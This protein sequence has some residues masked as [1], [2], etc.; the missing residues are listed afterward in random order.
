MRERDFV[1]F[2]TVSFFRDRN[3][4]AADLAARYGG[5]PDVMC[6]S[7]DGEP[8]CIGGTLEVRPGVVTLLFFA[9]DAFPRIGLGITRF[10]KKN[11]MPRLE[12]AGIHRFEAV[13]HADYRE[14]HAW[15]AAIG[16]RPETEPMRGYGRDRSAYIQFSK[17]CDARPAGA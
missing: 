13:S 4:L 17:V 12:Q 7:S 6:G 15:L 5:R 8:V 14:T 3:E 16:L 1:E 9:T 2:S 11:L 10:I